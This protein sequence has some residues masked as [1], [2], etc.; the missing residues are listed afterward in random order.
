MLGDCNC[1][2]GVWIKEM[3]NRL[4]ISTVV[5]QRYMSYLPLFIYCCNKAYPDYFIR[6]FTHGKMP[7]HIVSALNMQPDTHEITEGLFEGWVH[8]KYAPISWR[9]IIP[10]SYYSE[11]EYVYIT[12]I[13][14]MLME[15]KVELLHYHLNEMGESGLCYSNSVRNSKHWKGT[16]SLTGLHFVSKEWFEKT[17]KARKKYQMLLKTG[18]LGS[19]R[20]FDG[21]MLWR[22]V[23][24][25]GLKMCGKYPLV[26]RHHGI[27]L[28]NFRLFKTMVKRKKRM[29]IEKCKR[30]LD[31]LRDYKFRNIIEI[32]N[33]DSVVKEQLHELGVHCK[34]V[35]K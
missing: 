35:V 28:G 33:R 17:E 8:S 25:S 32:V 20:E 21:H 29:N 19:K 12:D 18:K 14:M 15:E 3:K 10:P 2:S 6:I 11:F 1:G 23:K 31:N 22:M 4:V 5:D 27:H 30:W 16:E 9:F 7:A 13:D 26:A 34:K 24:E